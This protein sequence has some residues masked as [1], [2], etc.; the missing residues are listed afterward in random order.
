VPLCSV[1]IFLFKKKLKAGEAAQALEYLLSKPESLS[2]NPT[3][4]K[5]KKFYSYFFPIIKKKY[6]LFRKKEKH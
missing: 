5:K 4:T 2:S 1:E 6:V 3:T